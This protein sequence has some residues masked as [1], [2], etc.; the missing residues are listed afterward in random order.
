[1]RV[2]PGKPRFRGLGRSRKARRVLARGGT[3]VAARLN[4]ELAAWSGVRISPM[5]GR[6]GYFVGDYFFACYPI[7]EKDHDLWI[8][9]PLADQRRALRADGIRPHRR[10][11][12]RGWV[13]CQV[14]T[15]VDLSRALGWLRRS[16]EGARRAPPDD[17][18]DVE[19]SLRPG[20]GGAVPPTGWRPIEP[21][22][23]RPVRSQPDGG[24][25]G[26]SAG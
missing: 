17:A 12:G 11:A 18:R 3:G 26:W 2:R 16:Y 9:L 4:A 14:V 10:F 13:E 21:R 24:R 25:A 8:R 7:R 5:F 22:R 20:P 1:M 19:A 15:G 6:W 23:A